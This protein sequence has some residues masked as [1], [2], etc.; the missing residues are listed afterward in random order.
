[1]NKIP[2][3]SELR[4][5]R[6]CYPVGTRIQLDADMNDPQPVLAGTKG[7]VTEV[8]DMCQLQIIWDNG[9]S[10]AI[11]PSEDK[12]HKLQL[13]NNEKLVGHSINGNRNLRSVQDV[14]EFI[15]W[16]GKCGDVEITT[17]CGEPFI[18]TEG[19]HLKFVSDAEYRDKLLEM[20]VS[21]QQEQEEAEENEIGLTQG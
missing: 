18:K 9:R 21:M 10:L 15:M 7:T 20:I 13:E 2:S 1:M 16:H 5:Y 19:T 6:C 8:D 3:K 12:F 4:Y 11:I 17:E 14:A